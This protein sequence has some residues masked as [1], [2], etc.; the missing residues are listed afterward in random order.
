MLTRDEPKV[1]KVFPEV[2]DIGGFLTE[3]FC[4]TT[5]GMISEV[6]EASGSTLDAATLYAA[7]KSTI[8]FENEMSER[9]KAMVSVEEHIVENQSKDEDEEENK[10]ESNPDEDSLNPN[11]VEAI[12]KRYK[13]F[14][15]KPKEVRVRQVSKFHGIISSA[16]ESYMDIYLKQEEQLRNDILFKKKL[17][18]FPSYTYF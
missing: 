13:D 18:F 2:W 3:S 15:K 1:F 14:K 6:L 12:R 7:M 9:F 17:N 16:Y 5:R 8:D 4:W 11:S 10:N